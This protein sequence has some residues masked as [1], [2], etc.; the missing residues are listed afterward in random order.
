VFDIALWGFAVPFGVYCIMKREQIRH[1]E[2]A[3]RKET[4]FL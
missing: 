2:M 4:K 1:D 3:G